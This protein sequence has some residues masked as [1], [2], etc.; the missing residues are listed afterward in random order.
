MKDRARYKRVRGD[1]TPRGCSRFS[2]RSLSRFTGA[3]SR[4]PRVWRR[5][6]GKIKWR[7][8]LD[9]A[10]R[11]KPPQNFHSKSYDVVLNCGLFPLFVSTRPM[12][13]PPYDSWVVEPEVLSCPVVKGRTIAMGRERMRAP[14]DK[15]PFPKEERR[16]NLTRAPPDRDAAKPAKWLT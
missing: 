16:M 6:Q 2:F 13:R 11:S 1:Q 4:A 8:L 12:S 7:Y 9:P 10:P 14:V 3:S 5:F 15:S